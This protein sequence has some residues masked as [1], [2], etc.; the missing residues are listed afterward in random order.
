MYVDFTIGGC[1]GSE[2]L[3]NENFE[4]INAYELSFSVGDCK[5]ETDF[6]QRTVVISYTHKISLEDDS[7][8]FLDELNVHIKCGY[9]STYDVGYDLGGVSLQATDVQVDSLS[10]IFEEYET[11]DFLEKRVVDEDVSRTAGLGT[12][13]ALRLSDDTEID[14]DYIW[15]PTRCWIRD[16]VH[17]Y[18]VF[19]MSTALT[20]AE[21]E[22]NPQFPVLWGIEYNME[23][24]VYRLGFQNFLFD[25]EE[26]SSNMKFTCEI[27]VCQADDLDSICMEIIETYGRMGIEGA[28]A[29]GIIELIGAGI[30]AIGSCIDA[31]VAIAAAVEV[32]T[33][34][35]MALTTT[36]TVD[37]SR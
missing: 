9:A 4:E 17:E 29:A 11:I 21:Y 18:K 30:G 32:A 35:T 8:V 13:L 28:S 23:T 3:T 6:G 34:T 15:A 20:T 2:I 19:D 1:A 25:T 5:A 14:M 37:P 24:D 7:Q 16:D 10:F 31:G 26:T 36:T 22:E 27:E 12:Y 33:T